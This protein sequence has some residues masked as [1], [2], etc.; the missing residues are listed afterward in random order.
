MLRELTLARVLEGAGAVGSTRALAQWD[1]RGRWRDRVIDVGAGFS[2][3]RSRLRPK[4]EPTADSV[5]V[6]AFRL[7]SSVFR[8]PSSD[9]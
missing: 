4:P 6:R 9:F 3:R 1:R 8:L 7:P 2:Q 5:V